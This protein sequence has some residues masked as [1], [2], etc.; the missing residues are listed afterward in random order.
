MERWL[1]LMGDQSLVVVS[2]SDEDSAAATA[3][4]RT[5]KLTADVA[6]IPE[7]LADRAGPASTP[8]DRRDLA[9]SLLPPP[10][11][12]VQKQRREL[13]VERWVRRELAKAPA[14]DEKRAAKIAA[15]LGY[16]LDEG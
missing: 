1:V 11:R 4:R 9:D 2:S 8:E 7:A 10:T 6:R 13:V 15:I 14:L 3:E 5:G 12:A 16:A